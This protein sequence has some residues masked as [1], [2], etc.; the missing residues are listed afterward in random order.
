MDII[1]CSLFPE[2]EALMKWD[3]EHFYRVCQSAYRPQKFKVNQCAVISAEGEK[4]V[5]EEDT[6]GVGGCSGAEACLVFAK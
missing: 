5:E 2:G 6:L 1:L 4:W 3:C